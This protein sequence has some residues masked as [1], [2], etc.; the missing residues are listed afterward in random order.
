MCVNTYCN[1]GTQA[2]ESFPEVQEQ[3]GRKEQ[4]YKL[5]MS[6]YYALVP[7]K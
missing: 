2:C 1:V 5:Q 3:D 6:Q 7:I 4:D